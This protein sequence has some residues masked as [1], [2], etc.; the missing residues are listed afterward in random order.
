MFKFESFVGVFVCMMGSGVAFGG[1]MKVGFWE[2]FRH[3]G[4]V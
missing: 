2:D 1:V 4:M 3:N